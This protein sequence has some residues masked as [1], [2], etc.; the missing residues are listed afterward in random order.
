MSRLLRE[1]GAILR[2]TMV[3]RADRVIKIMGITGLLLTLVAIVAAGFMAWRGK[4]DA[5]LALRMLAMLAALW[6][7]LA[8]AAM[9]VPRA[10]M[11]NSTVNATM[12]PRQR[13][14]LMQMT[15]AGWLLTTGLLVAATGKWAVF[16]LAGML[17]LGLT[18]TLA[19]IMWGVALI[20][21]PSNWLLI[22]RLLP[23]AWIEA[24]TGTPGVLAASVLVVLGAAACVR[25]IFPRGG[26]AHLG[27]HARRI[28]R[29]QR[30]RGGDG[31]SKHLESGTMS[32]ASVLRL[33]AWALRR[34]CAGGTRRA[35]PRTM[36]MHAL[37][38]AAHWSFWTSSVVIVLAIGVAV[39]CL[40]AWRG[41]V[42]A[43]GLVP[44]ATGALGG[45]VSLILMG[46]AQIGQ[47]IGKTQGEQALLRLTPLAGDKRLLNRRLAGGLLRHG[48]LVW[49]MLSATIL[50]MNVLIAGTGGLSLL[51]GLCCLAGQA[52]MT[53]VL[54]DYAG[55]GGGWSL[56]RGLL[57]ALVALLEAGIALGA[58]RLTH[59]P[60]GPWLM[61]VALV[62]TALQLRRAWRRMLAAPPA[63]PARRMAVS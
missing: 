37:G 41:D 29:L 26:D 55:E 17:M 6:L 43:R 47:L 12:M 31:W 10:M 62:V 11:L 63:F 44:V 58:A 59:T 53:N 50:S 38:P 3:R 20:V 61:A 8:W 49:V 35:D 18:M 7:M 21:L 19:G 39:H 23:Q 25:W 42:S 22:S 40:V 15:A 2:V 33:Y 13:R 60:I 14:R 52:S 54:G 48:L 30:A 28:E 56:A 27:Q 9:F 24:L 16:P 5:S 57:A 46:T 34:D 45:M 4:M 32:G 51:A 1:C 36:L